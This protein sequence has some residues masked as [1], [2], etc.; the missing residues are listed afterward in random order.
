MKKQSSKLISLIL[1]MFMLI[2]AFSG[3]GG[4]TSSDTGNNS[5]ASAAET[6]GPQEAQEPVT[7]Q[8]W[9][10]GTD[11]AT[12]VEME[13]YVKAFE[14]KNP[15]IKVEATGMSP[16]I[17]EQETKL[18]AAVLSGTYPD[19][20]HIVLAEVG[21]RGSLNDFE[22][23]DPYIEKWADKDDI[24]ESAYDMGKY[25]GKQV[26]IGCAPNPNIFV[27]R[28][29]LF[30]EAGLDPEKPPKTW[31]ELETVVDKLTKKDNKGNVIQAGFDLPSVDSS[32]VFTEP[33][34]RSNG[35]MIIDEQNLKP[36]FTDKGAIEAL[37]FLGDLA[38]KQ[39]YI[40][41]DQQ[42]GDEKPFMNKKSAIGNIGV[43]QVAQFK[44]NNPDLADQLGYLTMFSNEDKPA[45]G[46]CG[47]Q[48][49]A[50][51]E[52]SE[53]K[54]EAWKFM[55]YMLSKEVIQDRSVKKLFP[56]IR[57]SLEEE[58]IQKDPALNSVVM[59]Y[60]KN[61]KGKA[62]VPWISVYNKY[63]SNSYE[64][65]INQKGSA[66]KALKDAETALLKDISK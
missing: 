37:Q 21:T 13:E 62:T 36:S 27:Y 29:D 20:I 48:L 57:K 53:H 28:K 17:S 52:T 5:A 11:K 26:A 43:N 16:V 58:Y 35:S 31:K 44:E 30:R 24:F 23:L 9:Y 6:S 40:A 25:A 15:G 34:M 55:Q 4:N 61:G 60:V 51:G 12:Q 56:P 65:V 38:A 33:F 54:E 47:Y 39:D 64:V 45:V 46:F 66:E 7:L 2:T 49:Y 3:C 41:H 32:L 10:Q 1:A 14:E 59:E 50:M 63:V 19:V 8:Y 22:P 18:N 42:K